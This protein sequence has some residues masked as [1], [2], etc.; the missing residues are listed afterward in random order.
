MIRAGFPQDEHDIFGCY[1]EN[2]GLE[3]VKNKGR[4]DIHNV[5]PALEDYWIE[6]ITKKKDSRNNTDQ[7]INPAEHLSYQMPLPEFAI[8]EKDFMENVMDAV[9]AKNAVDI[10]QWKQD[11]L[12]TILYD[13]EVDEKEDTTLIRL[14][15]ND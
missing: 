14:K 15:K 7:W 8:S 4:H 5:W 13:S 1:I 12:N 2:D 10:K 9:F 3:T 11:V 6:S